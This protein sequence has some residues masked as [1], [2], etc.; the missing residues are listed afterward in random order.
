M[1][2]VLKIFILNTISNFLVLPFLKKCLFF[3]NKFRHI[4]IVTIFMFNY[5][6]VKTE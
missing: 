6:S 3:H 1:R 4:S 2:S 5:L